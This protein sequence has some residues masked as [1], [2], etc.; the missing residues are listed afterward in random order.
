ML[1]MTCAVIT[2][3][4][5]A[6]VITTVAA[7]AAALMDNCNTCDKNYFRRFY[8]HNCGS[9]GSCYDGQLPQL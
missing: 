9:S 6:S 1:A 5:A 2:I 8:D 7:V 3:T 4:F